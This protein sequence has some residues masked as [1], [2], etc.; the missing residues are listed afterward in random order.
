MLDLKYFDTITIFTPKCPCKL[1]NPFLS[2]GS[3]KKWWGWPRWRGREPQEVVF[4]CLGWEGWWL[5]KRCHLN[6]VDEE[7][8]QHRVDSHSPPKPHFGVTN[9]VWNFR[10]SEG[11]FPISSQPSL[12]SSLGT[13]LLNPGLK[14]KWEKPVPWEEKTARDCRLQHD[15]HWV[16]MERKG[17]SEEKRKKIQGGQ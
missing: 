17:K 15:W 3:L 2:V 1:R 12:T 5:G 7:H 4:S 6:E 10:C 14:N 16:L 9:K 8:S 11:Y 13:E